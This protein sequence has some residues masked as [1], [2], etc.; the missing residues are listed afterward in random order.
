MPSVRTVAQ[1]MS[2]KAR[3]TDLRLTVERHQKG[4]TRR[5]HEASSH[6]PERRYLRNP[7]VDA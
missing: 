6:R 3:R 1:S 2:C 5:L 4:R 7:T